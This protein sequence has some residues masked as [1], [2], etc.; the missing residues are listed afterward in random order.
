MEFLQSL[1]I[2]P[3]IYALSLI[4]IGFI[5]AGWIA[6]MS[7]KALLKKVSKHQAMLLRRFIFYIVFILFLVSALNQM[8][9]KLSVLLGAAGIFTVAI[10]FASQTAASNL[11]SGIFMLFERPFVAG[12]LITVSGITG[13]V[14]SIDLL[15][16][17]IQTAD[18]LLIRIPNE[19]MIKANITNFSY[20][21][22]RRADILIG[23]DYDTDIEQAKALLINAAKAN[24]KAL[25][26][27]EP[28]VIIN[29]FLDSSIELKLMVW[30]KSKENKAVKN[31]LMEEIK[32][33]FDK[34]NITIPF[35]QL[36]VRKP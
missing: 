10:G 25:D 2:I 18:N 35:P 31:A 36:T 16:T 15:S 30:T 5:A 11:V 9:F 23:V 1:K 21:P 28:S 20:F 17:K 14:D 34:E 26:T 6:R 4:I 27:P 13:T 7:Q 33:V 22:T 12:D 19:A 24:E 29:N 32:R 8:G 3:M